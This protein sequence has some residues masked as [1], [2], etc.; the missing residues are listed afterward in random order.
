MIFLATHVMNIFG[1]FEVL[2]ADIR[3]IQVLSE[4][5]NYNIFVKPSVSMLFPQSN[6]TRASPTESEGV[7]YD[8]LP[9]IV[10]G[11]SGVSCL[12]V[13]IL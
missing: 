13:V 12:F 8:I 3:A 2:V 5:L 4:P 6:I 9:Y 1:E 11:L 7:L 10:F